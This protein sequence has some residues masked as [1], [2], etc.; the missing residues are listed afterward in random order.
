MLNIVVGSLVV[1][2]VLFGLDRLC[3]WAERKG[4]IYYRNHSPSPSASR[5]AMLQVSAIMQP[6]ARAQIAAIQEVVEESESGDPPEPIGG[7]ELG[8]ETH[9]PRSGG[10]DAED[11][12]RENE[13]QT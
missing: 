2:A 13:G 5:N 12:D 6:G 10:A 8:S 1:A 9:R 11:P 7:V 4:W 3:L